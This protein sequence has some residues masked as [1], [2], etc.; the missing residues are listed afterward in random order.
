M[1]VFI[2]YCLAKLHFTARETITIT[3]QGVTQMMGYGNLVIL[4]IVTMVMFY[5]DTLV[6]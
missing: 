2:L 1:I 5:N 6:F 4:F 3:T